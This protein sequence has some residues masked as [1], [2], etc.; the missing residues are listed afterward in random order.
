MIPPHSPSLR[1]LRWSLLA[2]VLLVGAMTYARV[3]R[4]LCDPHF[5]AHDATGLLKSDPALLYYLVERVVDAH[6]AIPGDWSAD[7]RLE[8]PATYDIPEHL[9]VAAEFVVAW[10]RLLAGDA[11]P[12]HVFCLWVA[13][14]FASLSLVGVWLLARELSAS[15]SLALLAALFAAV[16]PAS[17]RTMG[18]VLMDED[19]SLPFFALHLGL[20]ARAARVRTPLAM[21][22]A[23]LALAAAL[24]TWH[25]TS[26]LFA[27]EAAA[28]AITCLIRAANPLR[29]RWTWG[30]PIVLVATAIV[31]PFLRHGAFVLSAG[32]LGLL[33]LWLEGIIPIR[34]AAKL[35][36]RARLLCLFVLVGA[37]GAF[38]SRKS[39]GDHEHVFALLWAKVEH[40]GV[41]PADP[42]A[43]SP[44]VRLMWQGPFETL[45]PAVAWS[46]LGV[47]LVIGAC[48]L[49]FVCRRGAHDARLFACALAGVFALGAAWLV[50][51][52]VVFPALL[53]PAIALPVLATLLPRK[54]ALIGAFALVIT[55]SAAFA[56]WFSGYQNPWYASPVQRQ[57]EIRALIRALP[58]LVPPDEAVAADSINATAIL[59]HTGRRAILSPKWESRASRARVVEFLTAFH[60]LSP[61][62]FRALLVTK[63]R[64]HYLLV[65]R[66]TLGFLCAYTAGLRGF[67]PRAGSAASVFLSQDGRVLEHVSGYRLL[68]RSPEGIRQSNG[69]PADF[70]RLYALEDVPAGR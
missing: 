18:F 15:A 49:I 70:F 50:G 57:A 53:L 44:D 47:S 16:L 29:E 1:A 13:G 43:L 21:L 42:L 5:D 30:L 36:V 48:A 23:S 59:A 60:T 28:V 24:A 64:C 19:F 62:D 4:T 20:L 63:Y 54:W 26:F 27:L 67:E 6:G 32:M 69:E 55:Q 61:A 66:V 10:L 34:F 22:L 11:L 65:D 35:G 58:A 17:W 40:F 45:A 3:Q 56:T 7:P 46:M 14:A 68:Y 33:A 31:V 2:L 8:H 37:L 38:A 25:A 39:G 41:R 52:V 51:R 12:L 9:P